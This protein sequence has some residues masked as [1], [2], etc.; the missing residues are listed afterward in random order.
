MQDGLVISLRDADNKV[1]NLLSGQKNSI[2]AQTHMTV[3]VIEM[4]DINFHFDSAVLLPDYGTNEPQSGNKEQDRITGLA[5]LYACYKQA[6]KKDFE[7]KI[8]VAGHT[9]K[10]G[11]EYYNLTLSQKRAENVFYMFTIKRKEWVNSSDDK[12]K[13]EDVQQILKWISFNFQYDCDPGKITNEMNTETEN[14]LLNFQKRYNIDFVTLNIHQNRFEHVFTK[15]KEDGKMGKQTWGAFFDMYMLELL[16]T[17]GIKESGLFALRDRLQFVKKAHSNP[18]PTIGCGENFP[19]SGA[20]TE[21]QNPVDRRVEILFFDDGEE[22]K[23]ECHPRKYNCIKSKCDLYPKDVFYKHDPVKVQPL[24]LPSGVA[25]SVFFKFQY[26]TPDGNK[27]PLPK[28]FPY[29]LKYQ[30]DSFE[31]KT[32]DSDDGNVSLQILRE[33]KKFTIEFAFS[34]SHYLC[35]PADS[36][37]KDELANETEV[38]KKIEDGFKVFNL[39]LKF[40]LKTSSWKL[41]P[42]PSNYNESEK[43]FINLDDLSVEN[44][45]SEVSPIKMVL[46]PKWLHLKFVYFDRFQKK[47]LNI[48]Q[49]M[50]VGYNNSN[51]TNGKPDN[52]SNWRIK[53]DEC[54]AIHW[55]LQEENKPD[56]K[57]LV[58]F[59]TAPQTFI[60]SSNSSIKVVTKSGYTGTDPQINAGEPVNVNFENMNA[61]RM[62]YY[63]LPE[64][65]KSR[66]YFVKQDSETSGVDGKK[67]LF[68]KMVLQETSHS[69]P[70]IISLDDIVLCIGDNNGKVFSFFDW[71]NTPLAVLCNTFNESDAAGVKDPGKQTKI[72][73][74]KPVT[75]SEYVTEKEV[76]ATRSDKLAQIVDYPDWVRVVAAQGNIFEAFDLRTPDSNTGVTGARAAVRW[77]DTA[78]IMIPGNDVNTRPGITRFRETCIVQPFFYQIHYYHGRIGRFDMFILRCCDIKDNKE[79]AVSLHYF[80]FHFAFNFPL[81]QSDVNKHRV[82]STISG[83]AANQFATD[84]CNTVMNRWNGNDATN[85]HRANILPEESNSG[86]PETQLV[87]FIQAMSDSNKNLAHFQLRVFNDHAGRPFMTSRGSGELNETYR[88]ADPHESGHGDSL[89]D[90][91]VERWTS[92]SYHQAAFYSYSPG[93]PFDFDHTG[94]MN[95]NRDIRARYFWHVAEWFNKLYNK[96]FVIERNS[97]KF[98][99][100]SHP[101]KTEKTFVSYPFKSAENQSSGDRGKYDLYLY[102]LG[103]DEF[104][105]Y[106]LRANPTKGMAP[107]DSFDAILIIIVKMRFKF[108]TNDHNTIKSSLANI[109]AA[110]RNKFNQKFYA[111]STQLQ[112]KQCLL[113]FFPR[114]LVTNYSGD[115]ELN[116]D[117]GVS[118]KTQY[119][120][121]VDKIVNKYG[122]HFDVETVASGTSEWDEN[123][124]E[125]LVGDTNDLRI[126]ID[127]TIAARFSRFFANMIGIQNNKEEETNSYLPIA[128]KLMPDAQISKVYP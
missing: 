44:I 68:E 78:S 33:K 107:N 114:Y 19:A 113:H 98:S 93:S 77:I 128:H 4:E 117:M 34:N 5:V 76:A 42:I 31:E 46:D 17:L 116:G 48:P 22:P 53:D 65:W 82:A 43:T 18:A 89:V 13:V 111:S 87:W 67:D 57:V 10:K 66:T 95:G 54:Q 71:D 109:D 61:E 73:L 51:S 115:A 32:I 69:R 83:N 58:Q 127:A 126:K 74:Y 29:I 50:L 60:E 123:W 1:Q 11:G 12:Y 30:D 23:L 75:N 64:I 118:N 84:T 25:V 70:L 16:I 49:L 56:D 27:R 59:R 101:N 26:K 102:T 125:K 9:D 8:L 122:F 45:G 36:S 28:N 85:T 88:R 7:Q 99:I 96:T 47:K 119:D 112:L 79:L 20:T 63:D 38:G 86:L 104:N 62:K 80:R 90:E 105:T 55:I 21:E 52:L 72:G 81:T 121:A 108:H 24:P 41:S 2:T 14:A 35:S 103:D 106:V 92:A 100:P 120:A 39:P 124:I 3:T 40:G 94:M 91:Y 15:I 97:L 6:Q 110:I 37:Q